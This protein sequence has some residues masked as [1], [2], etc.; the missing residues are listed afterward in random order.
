VSGSANL[1]KKSFRS[2]RRLSN[3]HRS[4]KEQSS[5]SVKG[6]PSC[7]RRRRF[8]ACPRRP[9]LAI[10]AADLSIA[11]GLCASVP[12]SAH[13]IRSPPRVWRSYSRD[14]S[15]LYRSPSQLRLRLGNPWR[16]RS[17]KSMPRTFH[18]GQHRAGRDHS[19]VKAFKSFQRKCR[20]DDG[21]ARA[22]GALEGTTSYV[23][24]SDVTPHTGN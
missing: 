19:E 17:Q 16:K 12:T 10:A 14:S 13:S 21:R 1:T 15:L 5:R 9:L 24:F 4:E 18:S 22:C 6:H 11:I 20:R 7:S 8:V 23:W 3:Q 2:S